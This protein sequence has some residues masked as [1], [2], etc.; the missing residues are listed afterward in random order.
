MVAASSPCPTF[1]C[2]IFSIQLNDLFAWCIISY[3][4]SFLLPEIFFSWM[5]PL[6]KLGYQR[7]LTEK[8][9]WKLDAWDTTETLNTTYVL[10]FPFI[11]WFHVLQFSLSKVVFIF[12]SPLICRFQR[13][14][15]EESRRPKPRLLRALNH[16][17]G[18]R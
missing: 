16:C 5:N 8:D 6:M 7:P 14:W 4:G 12:F 15:L 11:C 17:L 1:L 18:G 10:V 3:F 2:L 13:C 9:V